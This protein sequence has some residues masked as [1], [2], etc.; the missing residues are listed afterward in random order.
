MCIVY[1]VD[2][3]F[4]IWVNNFPSEVAS[5]EKKYSFNHISNYYIT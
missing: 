5:F 2:M 1:N 4:Q 3:G